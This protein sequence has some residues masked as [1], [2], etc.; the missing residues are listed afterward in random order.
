MQISTWSTILQ[1]IFSRTQS[2]L[3]RFTNSRYQNEVCFSVYKEA[4][5][6]SLWWDFKGGVLPYL[7]SRCYDLT[8]TSLALLLHFQIG[9]CIMHCQQTYHAFFYQQSFCTQPHGEANTCLPSNI[10]CKTRYLC[11]WQER[12]W[13]SH[14]LE[15][16]N[17]IS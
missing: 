14:Q 10:A 5:L 6:Q 15:E 9:N 12:Q 7:C 17:Q 16:S 13:Q 1:T 8:Q 11:R 3:R 4:M 2:L